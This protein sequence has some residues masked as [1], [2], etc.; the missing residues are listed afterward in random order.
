MSLHHLFSFN[1]DGL[2]WEDG[3]NIYRL[4]H[5]VPVGL[6]DEGTVLIHG[7]AIW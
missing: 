2:E 7:Q 6:E 1:S 5:I 3:G 4:N